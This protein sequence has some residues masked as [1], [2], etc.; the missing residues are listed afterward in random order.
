MARRAEACCAELGVDAVVFSDAADGGVPCKPDA[1]TKCFQRLRATAGVREEVKFKRLRKFMETCGQDL[2]FSLAQVALRAGHD[3]AVASR[4][5]TGRV[6]ESDRQLAV[7]SKVCSDAWRPFS[8][9]NGS[10]VAVLHG[11]RAP[12]Q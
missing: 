9:C 2:G 7:R 4:C 5:Y 8:R 11:V 1:V 12:A 3:P 6:A 10:A